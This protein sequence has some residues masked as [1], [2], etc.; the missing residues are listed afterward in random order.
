[1]LVALL[2]TGVWVWPVALLAPVLL[3]V[4]AEKHV[5]VWYRT[6]APRRVWRELLNPRRVLTVAGITVAIDVATVYGM[7]PDSWSVVKSRAVTRR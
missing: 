7:W 6:K 3:L 1:M 5:W 4:R 2:L